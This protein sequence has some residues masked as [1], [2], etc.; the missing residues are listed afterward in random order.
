MT[1]IYP[2]CGRMIV[3]DQADA[4]VTRSDRREHEREF[5]SRVND[6]LF[7]VVKISSPYSQ[8]PVPPI[9]TELPEGTR[10]T[11]WP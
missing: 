11:R 3:I 8:L 1:I 2:T 4:S 7:V 10:A 5:E 6:Q 9:S